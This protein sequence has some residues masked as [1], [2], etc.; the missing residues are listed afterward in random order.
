MEQ[1]GRHSEESRTEKLQELAQR[2]KNR[3]RAEEL[4]RIAELQRASTVNLR[5]GS[6][7]ATSTV[8]DSDI[9]PALVSGA[10]DEL[11]ILG[12]SKRYP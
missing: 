11:L 10:A 2:A 5:D 8:R 9:Q 3:T 7:Y 6:A 1:N 12:P 4:K